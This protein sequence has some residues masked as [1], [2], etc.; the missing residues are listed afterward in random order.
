MPIVNRVAALADEVAVWRR[1]LHAHPELGFEVHRTAGIVAEKLRNFGCDEVITGFGQTGVIGVIKGLGTGAGGVIGLRCDMDALPITETTGLPHASKVAG[2]MHACGHDG[3]TA[4]LLGAARYLAETRNFDGTAVLIFQPA[5]E[6]GGGARAMVAEGLM[7]RFGIK[8]VYGM[9]N[10]PGLPVGH[11]AIRKGPL[12]AAAD[13]FNISIHG[14]GSHAAQPHLSVDTLAIGCQLH[15]A[16]QM[17]VSRNVDP[18]DSAVISMTMFHAGTAHNIIPPTT[19]LG[20]TVR[21]LKRETQANVVR[22]MQDVV[23]NIG[24]LH[25]AQIELEYLYGVPCT[26][27]HDRQTEHAIAAASE[28]AGAA[29][30]DTA[31]LPTMA[32]EDF[33]LMLEVRPGALIFVGNG[34]SAGLHHPG[35]D[36]NDAA[37]AAGVSYWARLVET[38]LA[39]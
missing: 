19:Q 28:I 35:Y 17:I 25:N 37:I 4:M 13:R 26:F 38:R 5:E 39:A 20:G 12:M 3:H 9:H 18:L 34:D 36:F 22:R 11:F 1:D 24:R 21:T 6:G 23:D 27:N 15:Q 14:R 31:V 29:S 30:I 16:L 32:G 10:W 2:T 7:D 8:E 33:A